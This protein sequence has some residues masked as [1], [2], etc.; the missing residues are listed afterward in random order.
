MVPLSV[1]GTRPAGPYQVNYGSPQYQPGLFWVPAQPVPLAITGSP[2]IK[3]TFT[4]NVSNGVALAG[5]HAWHSTASDTSTYID[6]GD[7]SLFVPTTEV[8]IAFTYQ[9]TDTTARDSAAFGIPD[10]G[11][12]ARRCNVSL[13]WQDNSIYWDFG[14]TSGNNRISTTSVSNLDK[15]NTFVFSAG[16][17]G[18][19]IWRNG[20]LVI[21]ASGVPSA[22]SATTGT[23]RLMASGVGAS[24]LAKCTDFK[25]YTKQLPLALCS[26]LCSP[27]TRWDLYWTPSRRTYQFFA[28]AVG[29]A[30]F[31][32]YQSPFGWR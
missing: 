32:G 23:F 3:G 10:A 14:G 25:M 15:D 8:T 28:A 20:F 22:R 6:F 1:T 24:D 31:P 19:E 4:G 12:V 17:R 11:N 2:R 21:S 5:G 30:T 16:P 9:K 29:G 26:H 7:S 27:N 13:P 18:M